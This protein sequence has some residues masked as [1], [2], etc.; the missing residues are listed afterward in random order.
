MRRA[1]NSMG[2]GTTLGMPDNLSEAKAQWCLSLPF[3]CSAAT[4]QASQALMTPDLVY[5]PVTA[6]LPPSAPASAT[7][8]PYMPTQ[9]EI[10]ASIAAAAAQGNADFASTITDTSGNLAAVAA[11]QP[12]FW[13]SIPT[14]LWLVLGGGAFFLMVA[15]SGGPRIYGR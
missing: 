15:P 8:A 4:L 5:A 13:S 6:L 1:F 7:V 2:L 14:W 3:F 11:A 10:D 9:A 12:S